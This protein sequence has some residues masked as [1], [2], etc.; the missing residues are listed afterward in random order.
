MVPLDK[1]ADEV[2]TGI[3][4]IDGIQSGTFIGTI[5]KLSLYKRNDLMVARSPATVSWV[6]LE[7]RLEVRNEHESMDLRRL[8]QYILLYPLPLTLEKVHGVLEPLL[9]ERAD[10]AMCAGT[11]DG[12]GVLVYL[13]RAKGMRTLPD[14]V[15]DGVS[16]QHFGFRR[17]GDFMRSMD[18]TLEKIGKS[19][20]HC[21]TWISIR[22]P[23][24]EFSFQ[25][26]QA[27]LEPLSLEQIETMKGEVLAVSLK[28]RSSFQTVFMRVLPQILKVRALRDRLGR[29]LVFDAYSPP[30]SVKVPPL[31]HIMNLDLQ[32]RRLQEVT[33]QWEYYTLKDV[34][35][36]ASLLNRYA[37]LILGAN[38]TTGFGKSAVAK[39]LACHYSQCCVESA[40]LP[41]DQARVAITNTLDA[42]RD[43]SFSTGTSWILDEFSPAET[44]SN[45]YV[46]E[47]MLKCLFSPSDPCTLRARQ[48]DVMVCEGIPRIITSNAASLE[49]WCGK[50]IECTDPLK[51]KCIVFVVTKPLCSPA[52]IASLKSSAH[53]D[54]G[55]SAA[56]ILMQERFQASVPDFPAA[57]SSSSSSSSGLTLFGCPLH[58]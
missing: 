14:L 29:E 7:A 36:N 1:M 13:R 12:T 18:A 37:V 44:E 2:F 49:Q 47:T 39:A 38:Q 58:R 42:A 16:P 15:V 27:A 24:S 11:L 17:D 52:W 43:I 55:L 41:R 22:S 30:P 48:K 4:E 51:R 53:T 40:R 23:P 6:E 26:I 10:L 19:M 34:F 56:T 8:Q 9:H 45:V 57:V 21:M 32:G 54:L 5:G 3:P 20:S 28:Q 46:N 35:T 25:Q 33:R 31:E 50:R